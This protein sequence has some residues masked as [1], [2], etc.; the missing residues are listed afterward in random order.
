MSVGGFLSGISSGVIET[1]VELS[2]RIIEGAIGEE[3]CVF[4]CSTAGV[5]E[6]GG[7]VW[8]RISAGVLD[9]EDAN[10]SSRMSVGAIET[11]GAVS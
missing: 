8:S 1:E 10:A 2:S 5:V 7:D 11:E 6:M 3:N 4:S 9:A